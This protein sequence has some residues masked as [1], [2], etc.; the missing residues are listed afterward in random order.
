MLPPYE[1][2]DLVAYWSGL[3][4][5]KGKDELAIHWKGPHRV[6]NVFNEG[7]NLTIMNVRYP[8]IIHNANVDKVMRFTPKREWEFVNMAEELDKVKLDLT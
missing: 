3:H 7:N 6:I 2:N 5:P 4:P 8:N 1:I